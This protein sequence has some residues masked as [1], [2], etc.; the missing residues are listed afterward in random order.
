MACKK[1]NELDDEKWNDKVFTGD[2]NK[3]A[4]ALTFY[5]R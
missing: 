1:A 2:T 5:A 3:N 4:A